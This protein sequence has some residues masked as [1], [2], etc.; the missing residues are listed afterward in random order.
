M[1]IKRGRISAVSSKIKYTTMILSM[2]TGPLLSGGV[3]I[4][5]SSPA[6]FGGIVKGF[7]LVF[8]NGT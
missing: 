4:P 2:L 6:L 7:G 1:V 8:C 5:P 3:P